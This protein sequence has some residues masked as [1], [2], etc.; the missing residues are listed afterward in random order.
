MTAFAYYYLSLFMVI[1]AVL[2]NRY[3]RRQMAKADGEYE[4]VKQSADKMSKVVVSASAECASLTTELAALTKRADR[5]ELEHNALN[6]EYEKRKNA[7]KERYFV[8]ERV[9]PRPGAFWEVAV[10]C[11]HSEDPSGSGRATW[12]GVRTYM[13][14]ADNEGAALRRAQARFT[15]QHGY[16]VVQ[17][18]PSGI[19]GLSISRVEELS[20]FRRSSKEMAEAS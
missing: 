2:S 9:Q 12:A 19:A 16:Q 10:R 11:L 20:T 18:R 3:W 15:P 5:A 1:L 7:P 17:A 13:L 4:T 8:F 6:Q 14:I